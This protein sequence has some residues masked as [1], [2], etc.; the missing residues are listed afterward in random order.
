MWLYFCQFMSFIISYPGII[1]TASR[2]TLILSLPL[3]C[4]R[5]C[6][7]VVGLLAC[8]SYRGPT[9]AV[10]SHAGDEPKQYFIGYCMAQMKGK[11]CTGCWEHAVTAPGWEQEADPILQTC[12][13]KQSAVPQGALRVLNLKSF[14][15][16][17]SQLL[18]VTRSCVWLCPA[19]VCREN[20]RSRSGTKV[21]AANTWESW[22]W[23]P[24]CTALCPLHQLMSPALVALVPACA[25]MV[26]ACAAGSGWALS[27]QTPRS[28]L[29]MHPEV[30]HMRHLLSQG[31][32]N[33]LSSLRYLNAKPSRALTPGC[34]VSSAFSESPKLLVL[35]LVLG[36]LPHRPW[37]G[38][39]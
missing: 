23:S 17:C 29:A 2:H 31:L 26:P 39:T 13:N 18:G 27:E 38:L 11:T 9:G 12:S 14:I 22:G 15:N 36:C 5:E 21:A 16:Y 25:L 35:L 4:K 3:Q 10:W 32:L 24:V 33:E 7:F 8:C 20:L 34:N 30:P 28:C 1:R 6:D 19:P 37:P